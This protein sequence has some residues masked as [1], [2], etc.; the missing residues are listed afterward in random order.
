M[1]ETPQIDVQVDRNTLGIVLA[2]F[3]TMRDAPGGVD[4][5]MQVTPPPERL[6][7]IIAKLE[8][9][10]HSERDPVTIPMTEREWTAYESFI[11]YGATKADCLEPEVNDFLDELQERYSEWEEN[12]FKPNDADN[13]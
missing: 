5:N 1:A 8:E 13:A 2:A 9:Y 3:R 11:Y 6:V 10:E 4:Y 7:S 12:G